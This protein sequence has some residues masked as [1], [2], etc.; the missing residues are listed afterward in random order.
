MALPEYEHL[1]TSKSGGVL[2]I[3]LNRPEKLNAANMQ[4]HHEVE[5]VFVA[6][7]DEHDVRSIVLTGAGRGFCAGGDFSQESQPDDMDRSV[8][9][10]R[11]SLWGYIPSRGHVY[12]LAR[13][14]M[15]VSKPVV[16]AVNGPAAG[17]G[18]TMALLCDVVFM[19][20]SARIGDR[21]TRMGLTAGD[22]GTVLWPLLVGLNRAKEILMSGEMVD[23]Q[24]AFRIG[25]ANHV[26]PDDQ[27]LTAAQ[28]YAK[29]LADLPEMGVRTTKIACNKI[30]QLMWT[31]GGELAIEYENR[32]FTTPEV[33]QMAR[34]FREA[35]NRG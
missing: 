35:K 11:D 29:Q 25:L 23:A 33:E 24:E 19:A 13:N 27:V 20:E 5:H 7:E 9:A 26:V 15:E 16:A 31:M 10:G 21:H 28:E 22:A 14:M 32:C 3:T 2:T 8:D 1:L 34:E 12:R 6:V 18:A 30:L 4:L 17:V